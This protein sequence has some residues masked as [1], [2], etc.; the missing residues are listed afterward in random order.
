MAITATWTPP[1]SLDLATGAILTE[2]VWDALVSNFLYLAGAAGTIAPAAI[3]ATDPPAANQL[4][5]G[6]L[7][8]AWARVTYSAGVPALTDDYNVS[9]IVDSGVGILTVTWDTDFANTTYAMAG[10]ARG[11]LVEV[12]SLSVGSALVNLFDYARVA[13]DPNTSVMVIAAGDQS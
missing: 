7:V 11:A 6:S 10:T 1:A 9:G 12:D 2:A 3:A 8:K 4:T 13:A 5:V